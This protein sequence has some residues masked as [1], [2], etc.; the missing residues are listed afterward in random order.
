MIVLKE[1]CVPESTLF[2]SSVQTAFIYCLLQGDLSGLNVN[3]RK[4]CLDF[5]PVAYSLS[6]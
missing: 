3:A 2:E 1:K 4:L 5:T 6:N